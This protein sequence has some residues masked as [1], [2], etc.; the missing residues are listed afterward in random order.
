GVVTMSDTVLAEVF[1]V[2]NR[3]IY[4]WKKTVADCEDYFWLTQQ[5]RR[6]MWPITTYHLTCLHRPQRTKTDRD[7]TYGS[8]GSGRPPPSSPGLGAR[9]PGQPGLPL[10]GS[11]KR[12][13]RK[14]ESHPTLQVPAI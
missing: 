5:F 7:G 11:R 14:P 9:K 13:P 4:T 1:R 10:P 12:A 6:N 8:D 2:S 3:T